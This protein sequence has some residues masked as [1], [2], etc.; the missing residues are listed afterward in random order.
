MDKEEEVREFLA[1]LE[2]ET[3][4]SSNDDLVP[5]GQ[6][7]CPICKNEMAVDEEYRVAIDVCEEHGIWL[8]RGELSSVVARVKSGERIQRRKAIRAAKRDGKYAG[9]NLGIWSLLF[10][11]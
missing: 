7:E 2:D 5:P 3:L 4:R 8:D 10:S 11:D 6:R 9:I 1:Q